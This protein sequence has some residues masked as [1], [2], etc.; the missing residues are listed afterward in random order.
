M[1]HSVG[2]I[3][4]G[5][6][7]RIHAK[8][9]KSLGLNWD[10]GGAYDVSPDS[11]NQFCNEYGGTR[12][13][14]AESLLRDP[15]IH[16]VYICTRHDSH[17]EYGKMACEHG[18][19]VFLEKPVAMNY[20]QA[21]EMMDIWEKKPVP[22]AVGYNMRVTPSILKLKEL[23]RECG[24]IPEAF[25]VNMTGTRFMEGWAGDRESGG[26]VLVCQGSHMFDLIT[27]ILG[28]P[29]QE[30]CAEVQWLHQ[31]RELEPNGA[32]ILL[33]L[34]NGVCGTL[35]MHDR[36]NR[37]YHVEPGGRMV[38]VTV[39]SEQGTFD[40]D[41]YGNLTYGTKKGMF[42]Q[43]FPE[44]KNQISKWGYR[45]EAE[46]FSKMLD[47][48]SSPLCS[49]GQAAEIAKVVDAAIKSARERRWI[50][51]EERNGTACL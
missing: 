36:G 7:A 20:A 49:I 38:N 29:I 4:T 2:F 35:L 23:L 6:I 16:T 48:E 25:R 13:F 31:C 47:G 8:S 21:V 15:T 40:A 19:N 42:C 12:Y 45:N 22:F 18:K 39:Y 41:A 32:A 28:S 33:K 51:V 10:I 17:V 3:G 43:K 5:E 50:R 1:R 9:L 14:D 30:V 44:A 24:A 27:D 26:G 37:S 46:Y 11:C 34:K